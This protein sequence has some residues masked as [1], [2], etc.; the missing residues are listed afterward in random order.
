MEIGLQCLK[1]LPVTLRQIALLVP[2]EELKEYQ[3]SRINILFLGKNLA[4]E[5]VRIYPCNSLTLLSTLSAYDVFKTN[6]NHQEKINIGDM[7]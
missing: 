3:G 5:F 2:K 4:I 6:E 7:E 1:S